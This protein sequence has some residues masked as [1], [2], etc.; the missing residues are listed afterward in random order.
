V[1]ATRTTLDAGRPVVLPPARAAANGVLWTL[2]R[3]ISEAAKSVIPKSGNRYSQSGMP[4]GSTRG[5]ML[6]QK[7]TEAHRSI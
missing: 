3:A 2:L 1:V 6:E 5:I 7:V 4:S